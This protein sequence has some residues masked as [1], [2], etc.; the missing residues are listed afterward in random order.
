M[1]SMFR[2]LKDRRGASAVEYALVASLICVAAIVGFE[3]LGSK[4]EA[5]YDNTAVAIADAL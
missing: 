2:L 5:S 1:Q 4:V 3:T